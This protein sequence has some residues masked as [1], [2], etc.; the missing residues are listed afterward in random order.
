M[1]GKHYFLLGCLAG[2]LASAATSQAVPTWRSTLYRGAG[3]ETMAYDYQP[4]MNAT[5]P[6]TV[7]AWVYREDAGR[8]ETIISHDFGNS[9]WLGFC[10][11]LRFYRSGSVSADADVD[12]PAGQ[13]THVAASYDGSRVRFYINGILAGDKALANSGLGSNNPLNIGGSP[14]GLSSTI[15]FGY[16]YE[17]Y[18]D[19][20]RLWSVARSQADIQSGMYQEL[21]A[22][23]GLAA[24]FGS[25]SYNEDIHDARSTSG[26]SFD[27]ITGFGILPRNL[28]IP[29]T[30]ATINLDGVANLQTEYVGAEQIVVRYDDGENI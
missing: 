8:C 14:E 21:R 20:I 4:W 7:E 22:G 16:Y 26:V 11:R 12:V 2:F 24:T 27:R 18:L 19:E 10:P 5:V 9:F 23:T 28:R 15:P 3:D 13:W 17:G 30:T 25:A 1:T 6:M 29:K